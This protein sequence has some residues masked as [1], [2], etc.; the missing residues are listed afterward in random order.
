MSPLSSK[1]IL[2]KIIYDTCIQTIIDQKY[3]YENH[4]YPQNYFYGLLYLISPISIL[5]L[6]IK[7]N[8]LFSHFLFIYS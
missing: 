8:S 5:F 7:P 3:I 4:S 1:S 6:L 2:R